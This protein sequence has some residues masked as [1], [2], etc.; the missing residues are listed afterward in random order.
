MFPR[1]SKI[2]VDCGL[3]TGKYEKHFVLLNRKNNLFE[4]DE[5][6]KAVNFY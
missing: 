1:R 5:T 2:E 3:S 6:K 4:I